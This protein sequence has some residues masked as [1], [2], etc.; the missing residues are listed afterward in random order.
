MVVT[1]MMQIDFTHIRHAILHQGNTISS[2]HT[3]SEISWIVW[4]TNYRV[5]EGDFI[6]CNYSGSNEDIEIGRLF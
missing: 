2:S 3:I 5:F 6:K 1:V 4:R